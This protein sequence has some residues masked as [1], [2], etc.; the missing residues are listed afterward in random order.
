L[1][2]KKV[3]VEVSLLPK[4]SPAEKEALSHAVENY[5]KFLRL[6][7]LLLHKEYTIGQRTSRS[8]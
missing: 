8:F 5:G 6:P 3:E 7:A 4:L 2:K 1:G